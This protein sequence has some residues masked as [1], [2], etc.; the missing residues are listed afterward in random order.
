MRLFREPTASSHL[1]MEDNFPIVCAS[2]RVV[3]SEAGLG[4]PMASAVVASDAT[5]TTKAATPAA[6]GGFVP[7]ARR[8]RHKGRSLCRLRTG[9]YNHVLCP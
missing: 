1:I 9:P 7:E 3:V 8:L 5:G 4:A 6:D 2:G